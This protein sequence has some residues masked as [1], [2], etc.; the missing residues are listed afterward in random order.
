MCV[1]VYRDFNIVSV[2]YKLLDNGAAFSCYPGDKFRLFVT[3]RE[4]GFV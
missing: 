4:I 1:C 3:K 2:L